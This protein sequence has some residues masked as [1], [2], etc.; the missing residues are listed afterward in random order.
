MRIGFDAKRAF[1]N[2]TGLGHYSRTLIRSL[3]DTFPEHSYGLFNPSIS[4]N[5]PLPWDGIDRNQIQ[6]IRPNR[7]L[8][9]FFSS[10]WRSSW[11]KKDLLRY[12]I[13]LF[14]GLSHEIPRGI[15]RTG[16][17]TVVTI[18]DLIF[19][20]YP[21]QYNPIDVRIYRNKFRHACEKADRIIAISEQTKRD[22]V[23]F[24]KIP[25]RKI[26]V[27]YQS[28]N[29]LFFRQVPDAEKQRIRERYQLPERFF[30]Y[31]GSLIERKNLIRVVE[32]LHA[33]G[34]HT[35][36]PLVVIGTG[37]QYER[38]VK[39]RI[40]QLRMEDRVVFLSRSQ[41]AMDF[42]SFRNAS[43]FPA[44]YQLATAMIYPSIFEGFGIPVLEALASELPVITSDLSCLPEAGGQGSLL[45]DPLSVDAIGSAMGQVLHD[46]SKVLQMK[47]AG[48]QHAAAFTPEAT[49][50]RVMDLYESL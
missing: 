13:D 12:K 38:K 20:R 37:G 27:C 29:P 10:A 43:D 47:Q 24:Y 44:I 50:R 6:E 33:L 1:H 39:E 41:A 48:K 19:E 23:S 18:H 28:C 7:M 26:K 11:V 34:T 15:E 21:D 4:Q 49:A 36:M 31:V 40:R 46:P 16:I 25:A 35:N 5:F 45:V 32:A 2:S 30:L 42:A 17:R 3:A 8:D 14:H 9:R 22:I